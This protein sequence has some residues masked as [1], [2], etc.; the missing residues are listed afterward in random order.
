MKS[1]LL[2][3]IGVFQ[4]VAVLSGQQLSPS[5]IASEGGI[6]HAAGIRL[7]YT[8]GEL[9]IDGLAGQSASY[10]EGFHQPLM[11]GRQVD[12]NS[13]LNENPDSHEKQ[14][15]MTVTPNPT[16]SEIMI[17]FQA[18]KPE[19]I[20]IQ[21]RNA[22][23]NLLIDQKADARDGDVQLDLTNL[24]PGLYFIQCTAIDTRFNAVFKIMKI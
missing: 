12:L 3:F 6:G 16:S 1:P 19:Q 11:V 8:L 24:A 4:Y 13:T 5:V 22:Y 21:L 10:T 15:F 2:L 20:A 18:G 17:H 23:G 14:P 7:E 9:A